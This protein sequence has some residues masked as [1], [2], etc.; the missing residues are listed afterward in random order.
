MPS[1]LLLS[2]TQSGVGR[3]E[4]TQMSKAAG[5]ST[6]SMGKFDRKS[7]GETCGQEPKSA[8]PCALVCVPLCRCSLNSKP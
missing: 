6:A 2:A 3:P 1:T 8:E 4:V 5:V 7:R